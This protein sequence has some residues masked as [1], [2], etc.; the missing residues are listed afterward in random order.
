MI[1]SNATRLLVVT[2]SA[3]ESCQRARPFLQLHPAK[4][5]H[6]RLTAGFA[7][8]SLA[9][10]KSSVREAIFSSFTNTK[11]GIYRGFAGRQVSR[12]PT[13]HVLIDTLNVFEKFRV[14]FSA[15]AGNELAIVNAS[16]E[17]EKCALYDREVNAS[18]A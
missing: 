11:P 13:S 9:V 4:A 1:S 10:L 3:P 8:R 17:K 5:R 18:N 14:K 6:K 7:F 12:I 16:R 2:S 15:I